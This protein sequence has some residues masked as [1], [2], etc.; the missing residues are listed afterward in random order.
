MATCINLLASKGASTA[1]GMFLNL[2]MHSWQ[3][4]ACEC[5]AL[6]GSLYPE[7]QSREGGEWGVLP[8]SLTVRK[9][10]L[11]ALPVAFVAPMPKQTLALFLNFSI[12]IGI[13]I[14]AMTWPVFSY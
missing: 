8:N 10:F 7:P 11:T 1:V 3:D 9:N 2:P 6:V 13:G 12:S 4:F 14:S 5:F